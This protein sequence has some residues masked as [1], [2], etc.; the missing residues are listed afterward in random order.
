MP[1]NFMQ[2]SPLT[3]K[4][5]CYGSTESPLKLSLLLFVICWSEMVS[6]TTHCVRWNCARSPGPTTCLCASNL[7]RVCG[8][9]MVC[10]ICDC[11]YSKSVTGYKAGSLDILAPRVLESQLRI[12]DPKPNCSEKSEL[13]FWRKLSGMEHCIFSLGTRTSLRLLA[14]SGYFALPRQASR[15]AL[16][17]HLLDRVCIVVVIKRTYVLPAS[18]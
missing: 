2:P 18:H 13:G 8:L 11:V 6:N 9:L 15:L 10:A 14:L 17:N 7:K 3:E 4:K 12:F 5:E 1:Q 16:L